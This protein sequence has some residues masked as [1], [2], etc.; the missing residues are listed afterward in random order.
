LT[1]VRVT[2]PVT[3]GAATSVLAVD[4]GGTKPAAALVHPGGDA[5]AGTVSPVNIPS[6]RGLPLRVHLAVLVHD[7]EMV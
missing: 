3:T 7:P 1:D 6:W 5:I 4:I 2:A